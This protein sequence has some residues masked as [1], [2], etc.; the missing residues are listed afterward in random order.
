[1][2]RIKI[3]FPDNFIFQYKSV[4]GVNM[5]NYGGHLGNEAVLTIFQDARIA[6]L[7]ENGLSEINIGNELGIIQSDAAI[8][9]LS[10]GHLH[11]KII[12]TIAFE[13]TS[14]VSFDIYYKIELKNALKPISV[15]KTGMIIFNYKTKKMS[16]TPSSFLNL[17]KSKSIRI[18]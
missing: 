4:I 17:I 16:Q 7:H 12:T 10:E 14:K 8:Q 3:T 18:S 1:M 5:I 6:F 2:S 9:Y 15:G 13:I 11:D